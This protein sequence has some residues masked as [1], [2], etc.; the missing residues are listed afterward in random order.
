MVFSSRKLFSLF[1]IIHASILTPARKIK[2]VLST[3]L[4]EFG[5][6]RKIE[7]ESASGHQPTNLDVSAPEVRAGQFQTGQY[8]NQLHSPTHNITSSSTENAN[9]SFTSQNIPTT[10]S[11]TNVTSS[12]ATNNIM[13]LSEVTAVRSSTDDKKEMIRNVLAQVKAE[14]N[15][16]MDEEKARAEDWCEKLKGKK[17]GIYSP[18]ARRIRIK[19]FLEKR[20]KRVWRKKV[21]YAVRSNFANTRMRVKGRFMSKTDEAL[22]K[23]CL[24]HC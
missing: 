5:S 3:S 16:A 23:E 6:G 10:V 20:K 14:D 11:P 17:I 8:V 22:L 12:K 9:L 24:M 18:E 21:E 15:E 13:L 7:L 1:S 2:S 19:K 4:T